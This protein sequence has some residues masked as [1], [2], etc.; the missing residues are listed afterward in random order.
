VFRFSDTQWH[1]GAFVFYMDLHQSLSLIYGGSQLTCYMRHAL[2]WPV[3]LNHDGTDG[4]GIQSSRLSVIHHAP[5][6][7]PVRMSTDTVISDLTYLPHPNCCFA[8]GSRLDRQWFPWLTNHHIG[9]DF[10]FAVYPPPAQQ[11]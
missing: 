9:D 3:S 1:Y 2:I 6:L 5:R 10:H 4:P 11:K 7:R 8:L